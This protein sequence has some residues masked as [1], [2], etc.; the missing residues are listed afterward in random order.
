LECL[1]VRLRQRALGRQDENLIAG[2][3]CL[4]QAIQPGDGGS[5]LPTAGRSFEEKAAAGL[6]I[7]NGL[8]GFRERY[9]FQVQAPGKR[10][11]LL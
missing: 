2:D 7:E 4:K 3:T 11:P 5:G 6:V 10:I 9:R 1:N 8:L